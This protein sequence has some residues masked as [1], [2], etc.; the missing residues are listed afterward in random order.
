MDQKIPG[1]A[2]YVLTY[3]EI[4]AIMKAK[5]V[6][7]QPCANDD[8]IASPLVRDLQIPVELPLQYCRA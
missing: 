8:Q 2:D 7:L 1:N 3:S 6:V 5:N 4:R